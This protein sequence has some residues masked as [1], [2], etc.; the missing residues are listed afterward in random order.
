MFKLN[1]AIL[2]FDLKKCKILKLLKIISDK[3]NSK[4]EK[5]Q[6]R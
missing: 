6:A 3:F 1:K 5:R 2:H 4:N